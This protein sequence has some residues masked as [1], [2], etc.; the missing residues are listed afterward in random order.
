LP[1]GGARASNDGLLINQGG[2]AGYWTFTD[3]GPGAAYRLSI[4]SGGANLLSDSKAFG[5]IIRCVR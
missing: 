1:A 4:S 2:G 5:Y 3:T